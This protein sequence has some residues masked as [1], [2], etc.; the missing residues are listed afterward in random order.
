[1]FFY[2]FKKESVK[3][4]FTLRKS[5]LLTTFLPPYFHW[6]FTTP[7]KNPEYSREYWNVECFLILPPFNHSGF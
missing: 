5:K 4:E 2:L 1:M 6:F 7:F 3:V